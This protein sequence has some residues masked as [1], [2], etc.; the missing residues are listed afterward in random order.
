MEQQKVLVVEDHDGL[1]EAIVAAL[2]LLD[3]AVEAVATVDEAWDALE[4]R[5]NDFTL[6]VTDN[7]TGSK[8]TTGL[9]LAQEFGHSTPVIIY[10]GRDIN[11]MAL[12][13]KEMRALCVS[14][15]HS[16]APY[17]ERALEGGERAF[18]QM[19]AEQKQQYGLEPATLQL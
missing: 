9:K 8:V 18:E 1:R 16:I 10:S 13:A 11:K 15:D 19:V 3:I 4:T 14:K 17:V 2:E 12:A 7:D 5:R 6:V